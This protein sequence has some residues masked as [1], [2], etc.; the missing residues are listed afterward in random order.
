MKRKNEDKET[1]EKDESI[2][3]GILHEV[4]KI[5]GLEGILKKAATMHPIKERLA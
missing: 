3:S 2:S 1:P 5:F 4:G